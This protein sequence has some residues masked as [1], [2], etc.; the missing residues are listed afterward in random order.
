MQSY[1]N[2]TVDAGCLAPALI[3][4]KQVLISKRAPNTKY[5]RIA[6][7]YLVHTSSKLEL[8]L[9]YQSSAHQRLKKY[10]KEMGA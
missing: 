6:K 5:C 7:I 4:R 10:S 2:D 8:V 1:N 9:L 3:A